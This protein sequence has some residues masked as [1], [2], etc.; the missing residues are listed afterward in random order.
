MKKLL[1]INVTA[2]WGSTGK[3]AEDIGNLAI[4]AKYESW[5]AYGR[6]K[7]I[8]TSNLIRI[9][10]DWD[11]KWHGIQSRLFDN[12]GLASKKA[13]QR[14][15]EQIKLLQPDII[16]LHNIHGYYINYQLLFKYLKNWGGPVIWTLHDCWPFTGHC[17]YYDYSNCNRW[18]T[19]CHNCPQSRAYPATIGLDRSSKNFKDKKNAFQN[20][21]N[22]TFVTVS[23]WLKNELK[24]S[25]LSHYP[26]VTIHNGVD[27]EI[28][29]PIERKIVEFDKKIILGVASVWDKRKG[30]DEF[31]KLRKLL[32]ENYLIIL[33]GL[34]Q[35]QIATLPNGI[36]GIRRTENVGQLVGLYSMSDVFV[37][38]T[39]E[40]NFPTT[41]LEALACGTPVITYNTGGS[42]EA[43]DKFTGI[44]VEYMNVNQL[45]EQ[46]QY[47]CKYSPFTSQSCRKRAE[48]LYDKKK[49]FK[50]YITLYNKLL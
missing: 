41:N 8:S 16:H 37:N 28:F 32:P 40:D 26:V 15:I 44:V 48:S 13:T 11:M 19:Q 3:I 1:Q 46:I 4:E 49:T 30:L 12:H 2:N 42:P 14:F 22:I 10:N 9:G 35:D 29:H 38:P 36:T 24:K 39:L 7:P 23:N 6:G 45:A 31:V 47:I 20:Y 25:F 43:I 17:A 33:V 27:L 50:K 34:S 21:Q 18:Q 5:I